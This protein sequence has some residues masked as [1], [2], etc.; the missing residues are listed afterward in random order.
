MPSRE[1]EGDIDDDAYVQDDQL[2][3]VQKTQLWDNFFQNN[4]W[5]YYFAFCS[6]KIPKVKKKF[7]TNR[8]SV[9]VRRL[10][11]KFRFFWRADKRFGFLALLT[12]NLGTDVYLQS[13]I[14]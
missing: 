11:S 12:N 6:M 13:E 5:N 4:K 14:H 3:I 8:N 7:V 1:E 10:G 9:W 2:S